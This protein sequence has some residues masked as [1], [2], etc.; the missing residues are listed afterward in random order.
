MLNEI[1]PAPL[2]LCKFSNIIIQPNSMP[3]EWT[4][5]VTLPKASLT[6]LATSAQPPSALASSRADHSFASHPLSV[7]LENSTS[8]LPAL[9]IP[10]ASSTP[11]PTDQSLSLSE[12][13]TQLSKPCQCKLE[14]ILASNVDVVLLA[15]SKL[16]SELHK[17][18]P[19]LSMPH[20]ILNVTV[21]TIRSLISHPTAPLLALLVALSTHFSHLRK[22]STAEK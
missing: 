6:S 19:N 17:A 12:Y 13:L 1:V 9:S 21:T 3:Q 18:I 22:P 10:G 16:L 15:S 11:L 14:S 8:L 20:E 7:A 5:E 4:L 2:A